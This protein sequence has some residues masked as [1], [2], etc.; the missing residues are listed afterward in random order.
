[1]QEHVK[2]RITGFLMLLCILASLGSMGMLVNNLSEDRKQERIFAQLSE[3]LTLPEEP[4]PESDEVTELPR[5]T[6]YEKL[7]EMNQDFVGWIRIDDTAIDYPVMQSP[8]HPDYYLN[9]NFEKAQSTYGVP[10]VSEL[11]EVDSD[12]SNLLIYGHHMKNGQMF[13]SLKGYQNASYYT[14]HPVIRFDTIGE[15]SDYEVFGSWLIS[16]ASEGEDVENLFSLL[17]AGSKEEFQKGW[18]AAAKKMFVRNEDELTME[19]RLLSL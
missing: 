18:F 11:C 13:A 12:R 3:E 2:N 5:H 9:H 1:M 14:E 19:S 17:F 15:S 8:D 7:R 16:N 6:G 4:F 10:Y